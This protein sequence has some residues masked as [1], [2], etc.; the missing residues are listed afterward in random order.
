MYQL[1][2][3]CQDSGS[4]II[5]TYRSHWP[6]LDIKIYQNESQEQLPWW[7]K[8]LGEQSL[9]KQCKGAGALR[10]KNVALSRGRR[11]KM[12][13]LQLIKPV[14]HKIIISFS[15]SPGHDF[16]K[17]VCFSSSDGKKIRTWLPRSP[18][19]SGQRVGRNPGGPHQGCLPWNQM[20]FYVLSISCFDLKW[21]ALSSHSGSSSVLSYLSSLLHLQVG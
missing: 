21:V 12:V 4:L 20:S 2:V 7:N 19:D 13:I 5:R 14:F 3:W 9:A 6:T 15:F 1:R 8:I 18:R 16:L 10:C 17:T 11:H